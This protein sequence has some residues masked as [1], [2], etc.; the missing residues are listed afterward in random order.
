MKKIKKNNK[1]QAAVEY[2]LMLTVV[3]LLV[4]TGLRYVKCTLHT[5]WIKTACNIVYPY[6]ADEITDNTKDF[7]KPLND[8]F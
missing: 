7:C 1:G 3:M 2:V 6:P 8:C 5:I 4:Y